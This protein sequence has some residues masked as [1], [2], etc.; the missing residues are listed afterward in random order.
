MVGR[1]DA[2]LT[3]ASQLI[4]RRFVSIVGPGGVGKTTVAVSVA[5]TVLEGFGGAVFFVDLSSLGDSK[6]VP[7]AIASSVGCT[8]RLND[9]LLSLLAFLRDKRI[10]LVLDNCEPLK[11]AAATLAERLVAEAPR[12]HILVT[13]REA[14]GAEGEH[15]HVLS[16]LEG[17][18]ERPGLTSAEALRFPATQLFMKRASAAGYRSELSDLD[19]LA[20]AGICRKLDGVALAIELAAGRAGSHGIRGTAA[21]LEKRLGLAWKGR[22]TALPRHQ[23]LT[24][25]LDWS[26][27]L[28]SEREKR[29]LCRLSVFIGSF[30]IQAACSVAGWGEEEESLADALTSLAGKSLISGTSDGTA[31]YRL[32]NITRAYAL[33]KLGERGETDEARGKHAVWVCRIL[34]QKPRTHSGLAETDLSDLI[35]HL[36]D[37]RAALDWTLSERGDHVLGVELAAAAA[38]LLI[39]QSLLGECRIY[40]ERALAVIDHHHLASRTEM[41]LQEMKAYSSMFTRKQ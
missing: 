17:P 13:S 24:S 11:E 3:I 9:P 10:L 30:T 35:P 22:R 19:A 2:V 32:L 4:M 16:S 15:V 20:V 40:S 18:P 34:Q 37:V 25:T 31:Q 12:V 39:R 27:R 14:L 6:L 28:L 1:D 33:A 29:I 36:G 41:I 8:L 38:P 7:T 26:Y 23:T 21:L 5:H